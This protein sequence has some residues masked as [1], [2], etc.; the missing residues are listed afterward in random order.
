MNESTTTWSLGT[1]IWLPVAFLVMLILLGFALWMFRKWL[2]ETFD[3]GVFLG[4]AIGSLVLTVLLIAGT[5]IG[6]YPYQAEYHQW[7]TESG[8]VTQVDSR[9]VSAGDS[10]GSNERFVVVLDGDRQ[11]S[12]DDTRCAQVE[13]GDLLTLSCK[14][15]WQYSGTDGWD[16]NYVGRSQQ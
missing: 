3:P 2:S 4:L 15:S 7:R 16:C 11:R 5:V 13:I 1:L 6:M 12:C 10:G 9:L 8:T 14:R